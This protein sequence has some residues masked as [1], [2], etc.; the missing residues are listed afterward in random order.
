MSGL[1]SKN[2]THYEFI[3]KTT[4]NSKVLNFLD[5]IKRPI[6]S[7]VIVLAK[8]MSCQNYDLCIVLPLPPIF[9]KKKGSLGKNK[10][11][12]HCYFVERLTVW[13]ELIF[14]TCHTN[15]NLTSLQNT[16][17]LTSCSSVQEKHS[18]WEWCLQSWPTSEDPT[19]LS[20]WPAMATD[21]HV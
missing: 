4:W 14:C 11:D 13:E 10:N 1:P 21:V 17:G 7:K 18:L 19:F 15:R 16:E 3:F 5:V 9:R 8:K 12:V 6:L 2:F 20:F